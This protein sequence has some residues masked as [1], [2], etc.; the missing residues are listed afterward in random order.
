MR[1]TEDLTR[2]L[3]NLAL[4]A[5]ERADLDGLLARAL[6]YLA[7]VIPYDLAAVLELVDGTLNVRCARGKLA[8]VRVRSHRI[9]LADFPSVRMALE[10]RRT[11]VLE[12]HH[13]QGEGDPY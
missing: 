1:P 9:Q 12:E 3:R 8:D 13:H 7:G 11:R 4:Y 5:T 2:D 6:D 10:T